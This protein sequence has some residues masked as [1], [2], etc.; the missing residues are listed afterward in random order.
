MKFGVV[1]SPLT[2]VGNAPCLVVPT[3]PSPDLPAVLSFPR[4]AE[5]TGIAKQTIRVRNQSACSVYGSFK[6]CCMRSRD[7][8]VS[9][10]PSG[11][12]KMR[13]CLAKH[14]EP[15]NE[16]LPFEIKIINPGP[17]GTDRSCIFHPGEIKQIQ[18]TFN[19][20]CPSDCALQGQLVVETKFVLEGGAAKH[21]PAEPV[22]QLDSRVED[23]I[24]SL[25]G[26]VIQPALDTDLKGAL[27]FFAGCPLTAGADSGSKLI[28][29]V[30]LS[31]RLSVPVSF[32]LSIEEGPGN[33]VSGL[34]ALQNVH[35]SE[36]LH[37]IAPQSCLD[38]G[39]SFSPVP[40]VESVTTE[41]QLSYAGTIAI[42]F[43]GGRRQTIPLEAN[44]QFAR[45]SVDHDT[46]DFSKVSRP[47]TL[48][49]S[50]ANESIATARWS[51]RHSTAQAATDTTDSPEVFSFSVTSGTIGPR[52][53]YVQRQQLAVTFTPQRGSFQS[54]FD[55]IC[56]N[57]GRGC[58]FTLK[59]QGNF[60]E[61]SV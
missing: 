57:G 44:V 4:V 30:V 40:F 26:G 13:V 55:V 23:L 48:M 52:S 33:V 53:S 34:F 14:S 17:R 3:F 24:V 32:R 15:H 45:L 51:L 11:A 39:V 16:D 38:L 54:S 60:A 8:A 2:F 47:V 12:G 50:I 36:E 41:S 21:V 18:V 61:I 25:V 7:V 37:T 35:S 10:Q 9:L 19:G 28:R 5:G 20:R 59:G 49:I 22:S 6:V 31:N 46:L 27:R 58:S 42:D 43:V 1:G 56:E 29:P